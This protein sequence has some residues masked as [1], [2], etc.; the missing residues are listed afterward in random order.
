MMTRILLPGL[1]ALLLC[2]TAALADDEASAPINC[3][4]CKE[5]NQPQKPFRIFGNAWYVGTKELSAILLT[6]PKGHILMDGALPQSAP[7]IAANIKEAGYDIED[8]KLIVNSHPHFDH[9]GGIP[10]LQRMSGAKVVA[11]PA[12]AKVLRDGEIGPDDPQ[13]DPKHSDRLDKI[14]KVSIVRDRETLY[15]GT[16]AATAHL[17]PGHTPGS[18][19]WS[20]RACDASGCLTM[21][22][23]DSLNPV[24]TDGF[25]FTG[26]GRQPDLTPQFR[27][28]IRK[29]ASL[30]C[31]IVVS[32]HPG[33]T[34]TMQKLAARTKD[35]N[36]FIEYEGCRDYA[37]DATKRLDKRI[38]TE[39]AEKARR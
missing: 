4:M 32:V 20:F 18:T 38:A 30:K 29:V 15:I 3:G 12:S 35:E 25:R 37:A 34:N 17:T 39:L 19:T 22:Y 28:S 36:P 23:A 8:V 14:S 10:A 26:N 31:D 24:S 7:L 2:S 27:Q 21:V 33:L 1:L 6:G 16:I 13:Y 9:A 5:W 11:S